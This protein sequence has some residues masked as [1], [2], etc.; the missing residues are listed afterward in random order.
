METKEAPHLTREEF[1]AEIYKSPPPEMKTAISAVYDM[2]REDE[3]EFSEIDDN[4]IEHSVKLQLRTLANGDLEKLHRI[5]SGR[6]HDVTEEMMV[7]TMRQVLG[8]ANYKRLITDVLRKRRPP[9]RAARRILISQG[10]TIGRLKA[11]RERRREQLGLAPFK[12]R[13]EKEAV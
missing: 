2:S 5:A 8:L 1:K 3:T 11:K 7:H 4:T 10:R 12:T 9:N 6:T 13:E